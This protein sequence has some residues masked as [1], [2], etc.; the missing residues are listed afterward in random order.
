MIKWPPLV[1]PVTLATD[2]QD[3]DRAK[4]ANEQIVSILEQRRKAFDVEN[5]KAVA[6][7]S[8]AVPVPA[9]KVKAEVAPVVA[10]K[11]EVA[12]V[13]EA[14]SPKKRPLQFLGNPQARKAKGGDPV[15]AK[16]IL[17]AKAP[18]RSFAPLKGSVAAPS[19]FSG[20][21]LGLKVVFS[22]VYIL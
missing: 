15:E 10:V 18:P 4:K 1:F 21:G 16:C 12:P 22:I 14:S 20:Q 11:A 19:G 6:I 7:A 13:V 9:Q 3:L 17:K 5:A 2:E 8:Q